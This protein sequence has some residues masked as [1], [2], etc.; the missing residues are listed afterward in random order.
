[1]ENKKAEEKEKES[2]PFDNS[3]EIDPT[4]RENVEEIKKDE[5]SS[6]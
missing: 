6:I 2:P 5:V 3:R 4:P 1:M